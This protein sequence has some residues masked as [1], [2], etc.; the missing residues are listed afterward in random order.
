[1]GAFNNL[2]QRIVRKLIRPEDG[3]T[4]TGFSEDQ[5][6]KFYYQEDTGKYLLGQRSD[7]W[8]YFE[9]TLSGWRSYSSKYLPWGETVE[10][11]QFNSVTKKMDTCTYHEEPKEIDFQKWLY[12]ILDN[13]NKQYNERLDDLTT[14][15]L[16]RIRD[17]KRQEIGDKFVINK[18]S[19]C[20]IM[21]AL[22][23]YWSNLKS[24]EGIL[25][26][27]FEDN[28]LTEI[29]DKVIDA[30]EEDLEPE[31]YDPDTEFDMN[32][33]PLIM[34]W[35]LEFDAGRSDSAKEGINGVP[36][37]TAA[38]LY[39]Y[40]VGKRDFNRSLEAIKNILENP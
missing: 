10:E 18:Q 19:F 13:I 30:L 5:P 1:M 33:Q 2:R 11:C 3:Y 25:N 20:D 26:V 38:E 39:D 24:L 21:E 4:Y 27:Y 12:G 9:P 8:Y 6:I 22:D 32:A 17:Y 40:L 36:L 35:L 16:K 28:M 34:R 15:E 7:N 37:T 23:A 29:Y 14:A 31:L